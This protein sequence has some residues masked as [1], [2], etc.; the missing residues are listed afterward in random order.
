VHPMEP[1]QQLKRTLALN[2][3]GDSLESPAV[4][5]SFR[6]ALI[7]YTILPMNTD[8][9]NST[10]MIPKVNKIKREERSKPST[11]PINKRQKKVVPKEK[12]EISK[13]CSLSK[14]DS[15][16]KSVTLLN[17]FKYI[18]NRECEEGGDDPVVG[19]IGVRGVEGWK[20]NENH[21]L[22]TEKH[23]CFI[24]SECKSGGNKNEEERIA[25]KKSGVKLMVDKDS[26]EG[27][28]KTI[29]L[30]F[31]TEV[32]Q[33]M[34]KEFGNKTMKAVDA[35]MG[36]AKEETRVK[37][38]TMQKDF[39]ENKKNIHFNEDGELGIDK[40]MDLRFDHVEKGGVMEK[41]GVVEKTKLELEDD[42]GGVMGKDDEKG[43]VDGNK[44][45]TEKEIAMR[46]ADGKGGVDVKKLLRS[47]MFID[48]IEMKEGGVMGEDNDKGGVNVEN[49]TKSKLEDDEGGVDVVMGPAFGKNNME[50]EE[51]GVKEQGRVAE[52]NKF[53]HDE[54]GVDVGMSPEFDQ[55]D[56]EIEE[57]GVMG[58]DNEKGGVDVENRS[59]KDDDKGGVNEDES[60]IN[61]FFS[62]R[63]KSRFNFV[64]DEEK[65]NGN[66]ILENRYESRVDQN[67]MLQKESEFRVN[68]SQ[69]QSHINPSFSINENINGGEGRVQSTVS[70]DQGGIQ[71]E[72]NQ[73]S[74]LVNIK[75]MA[76]GK[77]PG[78]DGLMAEVYYYG[79]DAVAEALYELFSQISDLKC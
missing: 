21:N 36:G 72:N 18:N 62:R 55:I 74:I 68:Q 52:R 38:H 28:E 31:E 24:Q 29:D 5:D 49:A 59:R 23:E 1:K 26:I 46:E 27:R 45:D 61:S 19:E 70:G 4:L 39:H 12:M 43:S 22:D 3:M 25:L 11:S 67:E 77:A 66:E 14:H 44:T 35:V 15:K 57:G 58:N 32:A 53:N 16:S 30:D 60:S 10:K 71:I 33:V 48:E 69:N 41:G 2:G 40:M 42:E 50:I 37:A 9:T 54:G 79:G 20:R 6:P 64:I 47:N 17:Y 34:E 75:N 78:T 73:K 56:K 8:K 63:K 65:T 76:L 13:N 7:P 51:G